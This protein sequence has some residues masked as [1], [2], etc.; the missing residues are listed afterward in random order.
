MKTTAVQVLACM[1]ALVPTES[2]VTYVHVPLVTK[3]TT[4]NLVS[5]LISFSNISN[6]TFIIH[7]PY[8]TYFKVKIFLGACQNIKGRLQQSRNITA[9]DFQDAFDTV[10]F[11]CS[12]T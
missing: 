5:N 11:H 6:H 10:I 12:R 7:L 2:T 3:A 4:V 9:F 1:E 8:K